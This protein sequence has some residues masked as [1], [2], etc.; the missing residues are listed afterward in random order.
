MQNK[1]IKQIYSKEDA[2]NTIDRNTTWINTADNKSSILLGILSVLFGG[3]LINQD[4]ELVQEIILN[5]TLDKKILALFISLFAMI[6]LISV[7]L[8]FIFLIAVILSRTSSKIDKP[9][10]RVTY[11]NDITRYRYEEFTD[12]ISKIKEEELLQDL[13]SQVYITSSIASK[14][15]KLLS[16]GYKSFAVYFAATLIYA[17]LIGLL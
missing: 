11:F 1:R 7:L 13:I 15:Y 17:L 4:I 3:T 14:K 8:T 10:K 9:V 16:K 12:E 2:L 6:L 5:G